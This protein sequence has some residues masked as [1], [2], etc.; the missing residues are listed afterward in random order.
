MASLRSLASP[1]ARVVRG[2]S[3]KVIP[4]VQLVPG[5]IVLLV[6]GDIVPADLRLVEAMNCEADESMLTGEAVPVAKSADACFSADKGDVGVG[7]RVNMAYSSSCITRGR[8]RGIVV[9]T[10]MHTEIGAIAES[11]MNSK[12]RVRKPKVNKHGKITPRAKARA[13]ALTITDNIGYF[14]GV[15]KGSPLQRKLSRMAV[16]LFGIAV[17]FAV[18]VMVSSPSISFEQILTI[19]Q[20]ANKFN[21]TREV[22]LYA[23]ATGLSIIPASLVVVLTITMAMVRPFIDD[24]MCWS[25]ANTSFVLRERRV[26]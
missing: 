23:V 11:L 7:D 20:A 22:V 24:C 10:G 14:L 12:S 5:D 9:A 13:G 15:N 25:T 1:T 4:S 16:L 21:G 18:V 3:T 2:S 8:A 19:F 17:V 26:W 6:T